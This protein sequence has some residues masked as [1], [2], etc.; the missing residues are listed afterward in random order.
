MGQTNGEIENTV[1]EIVVAVAKEI[2]TEV[3]KPEP[4]DPKTEKESLNVQIITEKVEVH[5]Y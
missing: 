1:T 3:L 4:E 2:I 5:N